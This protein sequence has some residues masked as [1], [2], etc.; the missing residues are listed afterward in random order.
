MRSP[1]VSGVGFVLKLR[2]PGVSRVGLGVFASDTHTHTHQDRPEAVTI[3]E[4][5][6]FVLPPS[7]LLCE[8]ANVQQDVWPGE[9]KNCLR[10]SM[11]V[12]VRYLWGSIEFFI[13]LCRLGLAILG[14]T[15]FSLKPIMRR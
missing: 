12:R 2:C 7:V 4:V 14:H 9:P 10:G 1:R 15:L 3:P 5:G 8:F 13:E 11:R 6:N